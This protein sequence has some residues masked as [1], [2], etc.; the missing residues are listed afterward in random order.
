[1]ENVFAVQEEIVAQVA[2]SVEALTATPSTDV[3]R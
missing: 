2:E 1:V 3:E